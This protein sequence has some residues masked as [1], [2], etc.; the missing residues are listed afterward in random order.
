MKRFS[1]RVVRVLSI[2]LVLVIIASNGFVT[3]LTNIFQDKKDTSKDDGKLSLFSPNIVF[4]DVPSDAVGDGT[5]SADS[6]G[7]GSAGSCD[8][9][10]DDDC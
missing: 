8:S 10:D 7:D 4:A 5:D 9:S 6:A 2:V 3:R 1:K